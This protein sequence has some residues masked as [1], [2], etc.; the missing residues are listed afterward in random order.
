MGLH[1]C[2]L[3]IDVEKMETTERVMYPKVV[4]LDLVVYQSKKNNNDV[5]VYQ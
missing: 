2:W 3:R 5:V 1:M 4:Y